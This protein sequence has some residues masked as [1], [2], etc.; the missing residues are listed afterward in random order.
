MKED[1]QHA[2]LKLE[3]LEQENIFRTLLD[4]FPVRGK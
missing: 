2:E 3:E 4:S 1:V